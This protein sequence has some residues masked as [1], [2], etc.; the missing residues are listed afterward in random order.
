MIIAGYW[1]LV[2]KRDPN[3]KMRTLRNLLFVNGFVELLCM[4]NK[5]KQEEN[6]SCLPPVLFYYYTGYAICCT[7]LIPFWMACSL[8]GIRW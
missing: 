3:N 2:S 1:I 6:K 4:W 5:T 8:S 7:A